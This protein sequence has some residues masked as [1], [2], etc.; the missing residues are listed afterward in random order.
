MLS[1]KKQDGEEEEE[2]EEPDEADGF[3]MSLNQQQQQN[4]QSFPQTRQMSMQNIPSVTLK[5]SQPGSPSKLGR[6][7]SGGLN[8]TLT[9]HTV[10]KI[11]SSVSSP[12]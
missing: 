9:A 12:P 5:G 4:Q 7:Q 11:Q 8:T 1:K 6:R 2:Q 3:W 10:S